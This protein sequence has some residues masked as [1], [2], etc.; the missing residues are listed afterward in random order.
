MEGDV[1]PPEFCWLFILMGLSLI[2]LGEVL[3][4]LPFLVD[5]PSVLKKLEGV[6][7][8]LIYV[9]SSSDFCFVTSPI[10]IIISVI[11]VLLGALKRLLL[12]A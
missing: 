12:H 11:L 6:P 10:L 2:L 7:W 4:L 8:I 9:Y 1:M 5:F 3:I